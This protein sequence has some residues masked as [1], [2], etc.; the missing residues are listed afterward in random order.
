MRTTI[1]IGAT[2]RPRQ[3]TELR[4]LAEARDVSVSR[5][6]REAIDRFLALEAAGSPHE[7]HPPPPREGERRVEAH[8][9]GRAGDP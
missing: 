2:L 4:A 1:A 3:V 6:L 5:I 8:R 7:D 9:Q